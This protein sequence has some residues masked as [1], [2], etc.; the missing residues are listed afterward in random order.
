[1]SYGQKDPIELLERVASVEPG[2]IGFYGRQWLLYLVERG[3]TPD[4]VRSEAAH[5]RIFLLW[6]NERSLE[7]LDE[8]TVAVLERYQ[9]RLYYH[10]KRNDRPLTFRSQRERLQGLKRFFRYLVKARIVEMSPAELLD[11]PRAERRLPRAVLTV[12]EVERVLAQPDVT[13]PNGLRDRAMLETLY[14]TGIRRRELL[15]LELYD[16][17]VEGRTLLIRQGKGRKDRLIPIGERALAWLAKYLEEA[18]PGLAMEPDDGT[19]FLSSTRRAFDPEPLTRLV[20]NYVEAANLGK[21]GACH[22]FRHTMATLMLEAGAD[23]R[24]IQAMLGHA[25]I[26]STQ[27]YTHVAIRNLKEVYERTHPAARLERKH[28]AEVSAAEEEAGE[29]LA[30]AEAREELLAALDAEAAEGE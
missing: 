26:V 28:Y 22:L 20:H 25:S 4:S 21:R 15:N 14:S 16:V 19:L 5:L 24:F 11:L 7:R 13:T 29:E 2:T 27:L 9:R 3:Y 30:E 10:R 12:E 17:D 6:C 23:L 1:M 8:V 18:R